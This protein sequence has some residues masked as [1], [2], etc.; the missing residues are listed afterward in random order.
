MEGVRRGSKLV[1]LHVLPPHAQFHSTPIIPVPGPPSSASVSRI[2]TAHAPFASRLCIWCCCQC[3]ALVP[4]VQGARRG[5]A[6]RGSWRI[7]RVVRRFNSAPSA[8]ARL[9]QH[10]CFRRPAHSRGPAPDGRSMARASPHHGRPRLT[11]QRKEPTRE[12]FGCARPAE[13]RGSRQRHCLGRPRR[14]LLKLPCPQLPPA[15]WSYRTR[16][17]ALQN[18]RQTI[19]R[20]LTGRARRTGYGQLQVVA[21]SLDL[22]TA[23][24][25]LDTA[26]SHVVASPLAGGLART[27]RTHTHRSLPEHGRHAAAA[28]PGSTADRGGDVWFWGR[29]AW[30]PASSSPVWGHGRGGQLRCGSS[31]HGISDGSPDRWAAGYKRGTLSRTSVRSTSSAPRLI[32]GAATASDSGAPAA[33]NRRRVSHFGCRRKGAVS[34]GSCRA[35]VN[36]R[37]PAAAGNYV[38]V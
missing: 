18:H 38:A 32:R 21:G 30:R 26:V 20:P 15:C 4:P 37:N 36:G 13:W 10:G 22:A 34:A 8:A 14:G 11:P 23:D 33:P 27:P 19:P 3:R 5:E 17:T 12:F 29:I 6:W 16:W 31:D 35:Q 1:W 25:S 7:C 9:R 24:G 28:A 2:Q